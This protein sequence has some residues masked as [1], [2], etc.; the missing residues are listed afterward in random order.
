[1]LLLE[2][3]GEGVERRSHGDPFLPS[4]SILLNVPNP[5]TQSLSPGLDPFWGG[6]EAC[7]WQHLRP[8]LAAPLEPELD[9]PGCSFGFSH[10]S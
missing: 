10:L 5:G 4:P 3:T 7:S 8:S 6:C 1:M 2:R 9:A